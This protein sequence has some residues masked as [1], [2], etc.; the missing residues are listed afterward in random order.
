MRLGFRPEGTRLK[1]NEMKRTLRLAAASLIA[2]G[3]FVAPSLADDATKPASG[4]TG[5]ESGTTTGGSMTP[6]TSTTGSTSADASVDDVV[7]AIGTAKT[8]AAQ[9]GTITDASKV[10][11]VR[12]SDLAAGENAAEL[13][14]ALNENKEQVTE[15]QTAVEANA[16]LKAELDKQQVQATNVVATSIEADGTVT[17]FVQ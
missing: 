3:G 13:E 6:D 15:L 11:I 2:L 17:V 1:G 7:S 4:M 9:I 8:S 10:K 5:T 16:A 14:K 12:V